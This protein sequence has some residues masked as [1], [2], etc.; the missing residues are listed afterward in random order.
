MKF[1]NHFWR[2]IEIGDKFPSLFT[3]I[4]S[5]PLNKYSNSL[6]MIIESRIYE[7]S[8]SSCFSRGGGSWNLPGIDAS[9][10][11]SS[12]ETWNIEWI[13]IEGGNS[14]WN[15]TSLI[16]LTTE[17]GPKQWKSSLLQGRLVLRLRRSSYTLSSMLITGCTFRDLS[18]L[19]FCQS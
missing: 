17:K 7:T 14:R 16:C 15:A 5:L 1:L 18:T 9:L 19:S 3:N 11:G 2:I 6:W 10:Y 12:K 4:I 13:F 8:N